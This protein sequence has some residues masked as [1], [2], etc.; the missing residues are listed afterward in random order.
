MLLMTSWF[1]FFFRIISLSTEYA[2]VMPPEVKLKGNRKKKGCPV[3]ARTLIFPLFFIKG[4]WGKWLR[5]RRQE[6]LDSF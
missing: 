6:E 1:G 5:G 3:A 4:V 2:C